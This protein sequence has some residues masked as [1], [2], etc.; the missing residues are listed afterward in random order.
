MGWISQKGACE[1]EFYSEETYGE[2]IAGVYDQWYSEF[3]PAAIQVLAELAGGGQALELGIGT[4]RIA[5]PLLNC[6]VTVHGIEASVSMVSKLRSKPGGENIP[7]IMGNFADVPVDSQYSL[8]YVVFTTFY[9]LLTQNEQI[10]CFQNV[11]SHL[12]SNGVFVIEAFV[13]DLTRFTA[14]QA[15][16]VTRIGDNEVLMDASQVELDKQV[17]T[18]QH[19]VLTEQGT[20]FYPVKIRY[21]WPSEMDLMARLSHLRLRERWSDWGKSRFTA[22]SGKHISVYE[23]WE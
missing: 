15:M 22:E 5:I 19:V 23:Q 13:P 8:V 4:G 16:R 1:M 21:V 2:H 18:S 12:A 11:A 10:R 20:R 9:C 3:D 6:G 14:G 7:V 17:I